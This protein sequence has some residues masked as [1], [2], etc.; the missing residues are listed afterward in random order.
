MDVKRLSEI[1]AKPTPRASTGFD[2]LDYIY[3]H[4]KYPTEVRWGMP[5]GKI[6]LWAGESGI[7]KSRLCIEVA[8]RFAST[9]PRYKVLYFQTESTLEDFAG[10]AKDT[11][12]YPNIYCSGESSIGSI[13]DIM[14]HVSP[15][16]VFIDSVNEIDEFENGNKKEARRLIKGLLDADGNVIAPGLKQACNDIGCHLIMLGQ[17]NQDGKTIKGG[18]SLPHLVD[19]ALNLKPYMKDSSSCFVVSVGIKHRYGKKGSAGLFYHTDEGIE[20]GSNSRLNDRAWCLAHGLKVTTMQERIAMEIGS[21]E[22]GQRFT[23]MDK[24]K[25]ILRN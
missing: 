17:L 12:N 8:K 2:E 9:D 13:I 1:E 18:T 7:G 15:H 20:C 22:S 14:Y 24:M 11:T 5:K 6:S 3:G 4:S 21:S 23:V 19:I 10:W 16:L 25:R